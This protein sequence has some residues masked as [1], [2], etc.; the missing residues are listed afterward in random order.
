MGDVRN[1]ANPPLD[2]EAAVE[3]LEEVVQELEDGELPLEQAL[4]VFEEGVALSRRCSEQLD[5][6][7]RRIE[8]LVETSGGWKTRPES[9]EGSEALERGDGG[10]AGSEAET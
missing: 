2:F 9:F 1:T 5:A 4:A 3:R 8:S 10:D 7:E 6:A